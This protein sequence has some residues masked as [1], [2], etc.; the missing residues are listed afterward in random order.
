MRKG[1][2]LLFRLRYQFQGAHLPKW[3][4]YPEGA[5]LP[6]TKEEKFDFVILPAA[7]SHRNSTNNSILTIGSTN[8]DPYSRYETQV[9]RL[10]C[11]AVPFCSLYPGGCPQH[12]HRATQTQKANLGIPLLWIRGHAMALSA[13]PKINRIQI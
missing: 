5:Y 11:H 2:R 7:V 13:K 6:H 9:P 10:Q 4:S 8:L 3:I 1:K 12:R